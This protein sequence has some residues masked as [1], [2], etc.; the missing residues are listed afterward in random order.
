MNGSEFRMIRE[1]LRLSQKQL[2]AL[3]GVSY[4]VIARAEM[5]ETVDRRTE[6]AA[7]YLASHPEQT[8]GSSQG[9]TTDNRSRGGAKRPAT[10]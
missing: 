1:R 4:Q 9:T 10:I 7:L 6:L 8:L 3:L 5:A 2:G